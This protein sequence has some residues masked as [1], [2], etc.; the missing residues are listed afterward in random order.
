MIQRQD[1]S[2]Y[3]GVVLRKLTLFCFFLLAALD[4]TLAGR[5]SLWPDFA[6]VILT[7]VAIED[8]P[9][10]TVHLAGGFRVCHNEAA[11]G[12]S[13]EQDEMVGLN[14]DSVDPSGQILRA[15]MEGEG[16]IHLHDLAL[17]ECV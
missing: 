13:T 10:G 3:V 5:A 15:I 6:Q 9:A 1:A 12:C 16:D 17:C 11:A 4:G 8:D 14:L 2:A 7:A